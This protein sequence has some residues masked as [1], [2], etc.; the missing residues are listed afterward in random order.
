MFTVPL[1]GP[2][3][4]LLGFQ[5]YCSASVLQLS[6]EVDYEVFLG[7]FFYKK[8]THPGSDYYLVLLLHTILQL[9]V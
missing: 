9:A 2:G 7:Q 3:G 5:K 6:Q 8:Q 4:Q 1:S